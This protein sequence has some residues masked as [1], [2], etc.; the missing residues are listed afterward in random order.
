MLNVN[1]ERFLA[2][3]RELAA[4]GAT[5][6]G[7]VTRY[8]L[9]DT[10]WQAHQ[11]VSDVA[12]RYGLATR[13][14]AVGNM[15]IFDPD[16]P[17]NLPPVLVG[18]HLDTVPNG[19]RYDGALG[20]LSSLE[21]IIRLKEE[22]IALTHPVQLVVWS[23]EEGSRFKGGLVGSRAFIGV[24]PE[25]EL[26][27]ADENGQTLADALRQRGL[28]P[29]EV[30]GVARKPGDVRAYLELHIEQ[31]GTLYSAKE[32][33]GIVT[34]IVGIRRYDVTVHGQA[35]HAGTTP[36]H[37]RSD[38]LLGAAHMVRLT[39]E[40]VKKS[41]H[42]SAVATVGKLTVHPGGVN[43]VP[44]RVELTLEI[45]DLE[46]SVM[47]DLAKSILGSFEQVSHERGLQI[48]WQQTADVLPAPTSDAIRQAVISVVQELGYSYREMPSGAGHDAQSLTRICPTGMLF[49]PSVDGISHS[50]KEF[51]PDEDCM[52]GATALLNTIAVL[53]R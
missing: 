16:Q 5:P 11:W 46:P 12:S 37:L 48:T 20:V 25:Q 50:P 43:V 41:Q 4:I 18:S 42:H 49:V 28:N 52:R 35:N 2:S 17:A 19:G 23:E 14:D 39:E 32:Q 22:G 31:G 9:S 24:M 40:I 8:A 34:G 26:G 36:M 15:F 3:L 30:G 45:R 51:T 10:D 6:A 44:G 27:E 29:D 53:Q 1:E 7:G 47:D 21:T 38:A 13:F 33:I